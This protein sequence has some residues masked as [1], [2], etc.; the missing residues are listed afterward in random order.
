MA[1]PIDISVRLHPDMVVW[2]DSIGFAIRREHSM[3][4]GADANVSTVEMDLHSGTHVESALHFMDGGDPLEVVPLTAFV[5]PAYV[6]HVPGAAVVGPAELEMVPARVERLLLRTRNS[7]GGLQQGQFRPDYVALNAE[8]A[9]WIADHEIRLV[10]ID[11]LSI[12]RWGDGP[13]THRILMRAGVVILEGLDLSSVEEG[14]YRLTCLPLA[15][16]GAE[17]SPVRAILEVMP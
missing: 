7:D 4:A 12:Q 15:L 1:E 6:L 11:S 16:S 3:A 17:A 8:G 9:Q 14:T 13:E 5:G 10:G 2:P